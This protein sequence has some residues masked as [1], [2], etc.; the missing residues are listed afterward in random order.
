MNGK[1]QSLNVGAQIDARLRTG[2]QQHALEIGAMNHDMRR[3]PAGVR[4]RAQRHAHELGA[5]GAAPNA[6]SL[7][8]QSR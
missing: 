4:Q 8:R 7:G 3:A 1:A 5:V 2:F 6:Q